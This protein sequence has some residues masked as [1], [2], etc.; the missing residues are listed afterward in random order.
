MNL[1]RAAL[2]EAHNQALEG[3]NLKAIAERFTDYPGGFFKYHEPYDVRKSLMVPQLAG[4][5]EK[6]DEGDISGIIE[7]ESGYYFVRLVNK[8]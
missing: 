4:Q 3:T 5:I 8:D 1:R 7:G 2:E 6:L